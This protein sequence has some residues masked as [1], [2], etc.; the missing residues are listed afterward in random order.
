M[1]RDARAIFLRDDIDGVAV[2]AVN[3]RSRGQ[4]DDAVLVRQ[5]DLDVQAATA[6][7]ERGVELGKASLEELDVLW[8][9][10]KR[11]RD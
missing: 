4:H 7:R 3:D 1:L 6:A 8:D 5:F 10:V 11:K 2:G 9:E